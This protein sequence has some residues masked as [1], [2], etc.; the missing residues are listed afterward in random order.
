MRSP[1]PQLGRS[2]HSNWQ[3]STAKTNCYKNTRII[4]TERE[5][6]REMKLLKWKEMLKYGK[7]IHSCII[8][9]FQVMAGND[10]LPK[11]KNMS[12]FAYML[13][14]KILN[15]TT[16]NVHSWEMIKED[17]FTWSFPFFPYV[18]ICILLLGS[19]R[20]KYHYFF[21]KFELQYFKN[22]LWKSKTTS[23][24]INFVKYF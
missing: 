7:S 4:K 21:K 11:H 17:D 23:K 3:P 1:S 2:P 14:E 20:N 19:L 5:R 6:E 8:I 12:A 22:G 15:R 24:W 18:N 9:W 16:D 13:K 10:M